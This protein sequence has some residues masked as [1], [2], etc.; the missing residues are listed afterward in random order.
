MK[1]FYWSPHIS[2][3]ATVTAVIN[4][5]AALSKHSKNKINS[6]IINSIGEWDDYRNELSEK[7]VDVINIFKKESF[8]NLPKFGFLRSR[9]SY[10]KIF[11]LSFFSLKR[12]LKNEKPKYLIIHLITSLPIVLNFLFNFE[13]KTI[14]RISGHPK[15]NFFRKYLW[16]IMGQK[17]FMI[18]C[19]TSAT[20]QYLIDSN[21]FDKEKIS[22]LKDPIVNISKINSLKNKETNYDFDKDKKY[23]VSIGRL[24]K[25]K[26]FLFLIKCFNIISKK[27]PNYKLIIIG[28]GEL[29]ID[30]ERY[31]KDLNLK[32]KIIILPFQKNIF[33]F[34][35]KCNCF[36]LSSLWEDPGFVLIEA[37]S[38]GTPVISSNC[39]NGPTE[40]LSEGEGGFIY[41]SDNVESMIES[42]ENFINCSSQDLKKKIIRA[43]KESKNYTMLSHFNKLKAILK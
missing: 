10:W 25:Q 4:S 32:E 11:I 15:L 33:N 24:T 43:K 35:S 36:V 38:V 6:T 7:K 14:L 19:P 30:I 42:F 22:V 39:P 34:L 2:H 21:I 20:A 29:K 40:I 23:I 27:Y 8:K 12:L 18:V 37:A 16:K 5:A 17:L 41:K 28:E 9:F 1:V 13:T 3:V 31:I 26:N